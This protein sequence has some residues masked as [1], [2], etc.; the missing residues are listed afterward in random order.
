MPKPIF[1]TKAAG[2]REVFSLGKLRYSLQK[3]GARAK[4]I[5]DILQQI[6]KELRPGMS[7]AT[8][9]RLAFGLLKA[10]GNHYAARYNLKRSIMAIGP[11]GFPFEK[12]FAALLEK[13]GYKTYT[14]QTFQGKCISHEIDVVAEIPD[15]NI[16]AIIECK[17]HIRPGGKTGAKDILYTHA[18]FMDVNNQWVA[19]RKQGA[20][21][22]SGELQSWLVTNTKVTSEVKKYGLCAGV[23]VISWDYP[24]GQ[25]L[26]NFVER[27]GL[28]PLTSLISLSNYQ[29]RYL[30]RLGV[31]L[32]KDVLNYKNQLKRL[33]VVNGKL[34]RLESEIQAL[35]G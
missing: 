30:L 6:R 1:I 32:C 15:K 28:Y 2:D 31:V 21:P 5:E 7:T 18:R 35:C 13:Q 22:Q 14:N 3:S 24:A 33:G 17:F 26:Q 34:T 27:D 20:K 19:K 25:S 9:Y 12:Y 10:V 29:K 23:K 4:E 16:H 11:S 8:I